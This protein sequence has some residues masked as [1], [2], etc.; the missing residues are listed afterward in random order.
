MF[1]RLEKVKFH[2]DLRKVKEAGL[3]RENLTRPLEDRDFCE[4][5]N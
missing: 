2:A 4:D 5:E 3:L 1:Y